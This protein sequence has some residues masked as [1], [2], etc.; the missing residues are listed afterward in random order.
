MLDATAVIHLARVGKLKLIPQVCQAHITE[1]VYA[2]TVDRGRD[3]PEAPVIRSHVDR[4]ELTF[5]RVKDRSLLEALRRHPEIHSGEAETLAA[6]RE[7]DALAVVDEKEARAVGR[8]YGIRQAPGTLF[9]L[10]L[11]LTQGKIGVEDADKNLTEMVA[12][13]LYLDPKTLLKAKEKLEGYR[14]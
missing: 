11:L 14:S 13:G 7:L 4:G 8:V 10:F 6:A 5:Y 12:S 3:S 2:E 9:L 1:E